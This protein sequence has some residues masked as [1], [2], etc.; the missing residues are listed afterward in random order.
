MG[1]PATVRYCIRDRETGAI[2]AEG[3]ARE[4]AE[5]LGVTD[6]TIRRWGLNG[7]HQKWKVTRTGGK[8]SQAAVVPDGDAAAVRSWDAFMEPLRKKYGIEVKRW[9]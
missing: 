9:P 2:A 4:C 6:N 1:V 3:S 8:I 7:C 5:R